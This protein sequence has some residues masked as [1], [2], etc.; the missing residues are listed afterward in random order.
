M[1]RRPLLKLS[2]GLC[3]ALLPAA[4]RA[5]TKKAVTFWYEAATPPQQQA[6]SSAL[7]KL[8][9]AAHPSEDLQI[10]YRG[11]DV[12]KQLRIALLSG[13]GPDVVY[14]AGP[15]YVATMAQAKELLPLTSY[16]AKYGWNDKIIPVLLQTGLYNGTLY[17]LPKTYETMHL[18]YDKVLFAQNGWTPPK[19]L[20]ELD[21]LAEAMKAKGLVP[22]GAG[23]ADWR[24]SNE[25]YITL[26]LNNYAGPDNVA[27]ALRGEMPWT[28][29]M[30]VQAIDILKGWY[31]RG[32]FGSNYFSL[33]D[34]QAFATI[35]NGK[36]GM[37]PNG[38]WAFGYVP[39]YF[40]EKAHKLGVVPFPTLRDGLAYPI[41]P[42]GIGSTLSINKNA[43]NPDGAAEVFDMIFSK[44]FYDRITK[45]WSG[46]WNIPLVDR[47][48]VDLA[49]NTSPVYAE[50][51][52]SLHDAVG[53]GQYGYTTWTFW[54]PAT[55]EYMINGIEQVWLGK[56]STEAYLKKVDA[57]FK[58]EK[59]E[60]R[61]PPLPGR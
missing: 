7:V 20:A 12:D 42:L 22:F 40:D 21:Q 60:G 58:R 25:W 49:T 14:T 33:T 19:T 56:V 59:R 31:Q 3:F 4:V 15:G 35:A 26:V 2:T 38:T 48:G 18:F 5:Q 11:E 55:E 8:F 44:P 34:E 53:K 29:P 43:A 23:N 45:T 32:Y 52:A 51:I 37:S 47:S 17:A 10:L 54:P 1:K 61:V 16:A 39:T 24:G 30:F 57:L 28:D 50:T 36:A 27:K 9:D 41:Y 13:S 46:D 6:L